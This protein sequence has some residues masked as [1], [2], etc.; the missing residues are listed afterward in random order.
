MEEGN[1]SGGMRECEVREVKEKAT[2]II[3]QLVV[4]VVLL[5]M[6]VGNS[7]KC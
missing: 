2:S 3:Q 6:A 5:W 4:E 1:E 7:E